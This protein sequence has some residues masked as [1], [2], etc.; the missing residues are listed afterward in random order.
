MNKT[1][2]NPF[3]INQFLHTLYDEGLLTLQIS[4]TSKIWQWN[5]EQITALNITDNVVELMINKLKK[6]PKSAQ[7]IIRLAACIGN[8]FDLAT[9]AIIYEKSTN[10]TF[11][12]IMPA[13]TEG[14]ILPSSSLKMN[15]ENIQSASLVIHNFHFSHDRVQQAAYKLIN[16]DQKKVVHLQI[17]QLLLKNIPKTKLLEHIFDIVGHLNKGIESVRNEQIANLNLIAGKKAKLATAYEAAI[18]YLEFGIGYLPANEWKTEYDLTFNLYIEV[19]EAKYINGGHE[20]ANEY[21]AIVLQQAENLLD[22][23][24]IYNIKIPFYI[25]QNRMQEALDTGLQVLEMLEISLLHSPPKKLVIEELYSLPEMTDSTKLAALKI[26]ATFYASTLITKPSLVPSIVFTMLNLC[27]TGGNSSQA[28]FAYVS[29]GAILCNTGQIILGYKF[30]KLALNILEQH[31]AKNINCKV[32]HLYHALINHL[33]EPAGN[34]IAALRD[35]IQAGM[36]VEDIEFSGYSSL[37]YCSNIFLTGKILEKV[38]QEHEYYIAK[39]QQNKQEYSLYYAKVWG[40]LALNLTS[41]TKNKLNLNGKLFDETSIKI[42]QAANNFTPLFCI[43]LSKCMLSYWFKDYKNAVIN[44]VQAEQYQQSMATLM[45]VSQLPFYYSLSLLAKYSTVNNSEQTKYIKK[46]AINQQNIALLVEHA[47]MS[48]QHKY[49]LVKAEK[50][51]ILGNEWQAVKLY[52]KAIA[53]A[54]KSQYIH[55]EALA[56]EL[57]AEFYLAQKMEKIAQTYI[58]EANY[59]YQQWGAITK[60]NDLENK[61]PQWLNETPNLAK[62]DSTIA[63]TRIASTSKQAGSQW[64]D[65]NSIIKASQTLSGEIILKQLLEK[66]MQIVIENAGAEIG[67]LLLP[68][69]NNWFIEA[70]SHINNTDVTV[71]QSIPIKDNIPINIIQYVI[72][73]RTN[74]VLSNAVQEGNFTQDQYIIEHATKSILCMP[75]LNQNQLTGILYLENNLIAG[76]FTPK[77]LEI[78]NLLSSQIAISI[79]NAR[80]YT[81][82]QESEQTLKQFL[83]AMPIGVTVLDAKGKTY[84][85]NKQAQK[86]LTKKNNS[87]S[88]SESYQLYHR[89]TN[90]LYS[91]RS[92]G[93]ANF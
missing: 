28:A 75:L 53:G 69:Q 52:D 1:V 34:S 61:Y 35:N 64:L 5:I 4:E 73:T 47:P 93:S 91:T 92:M 88:L 72:R 51:R 43:Y 33:N 46:I 31:E 45:P 2:G 22:K 37:D 70:K 83:E 65:L 78:L 32:H 76:T 55:E 20:Q 84:F 29:Y 68:K 42:L 21:S 58:K 10:E 80:M 13:L 86:I 39:L 12:N 49:D 87:T 6:L 26:L 7:N 66:M 54:K 3:F 50:A 63:M 79:E 8:E 36:E 67:F 48:Y 57:A 82:L 90:Q 40:Q 18:K 74:I 85:T 16:N 23:I 38:Q 24:K 41:E 9:L 14:F 60:V 27:V 81:E 44:A 77:R 56:C 62:I 25:T 30:G 71:L 19:I 17:G 59:Y 15:G 89:G 11:Q